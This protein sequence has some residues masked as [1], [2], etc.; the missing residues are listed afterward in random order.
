MVSEAWRRGWH[1]NGVGMGSS[2]VQL[3]CVMET[4]RWSRLHG[5]AR[6]CRLAAVWRPEEVMVVRT[7][8]IT[9]WLMLIGDDSGNRRLWAFSRTSALFKR[10]TFSLSWSTCKC[11]TEGGNPQALRWKSICFNIT[12]SF[13]TTL[14]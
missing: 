13:N 14:I 9:C 4:R 2:R 1:Q 12:I 11:N 6:W 10:G 8:S 3:P 7:S 5:G